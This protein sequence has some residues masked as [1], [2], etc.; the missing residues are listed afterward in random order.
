[1]FFL[2][3]ESSTGI[4]DD[5]KL[6]VRSDLGQNSSTGLTAS[7]WQTS[8]TRAYSSLSSGSRVL[9]S[10]LFLILNTLCLPVLAGVLISKGIL[11]WSVL[12]EV[13]SVG[14]SFS[15]AI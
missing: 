10:E 8:V 15:H 1:M 6:S 3:L 11:A 12:S 13:R 4:A 5:L 7:P 14:Q 2:I 9:I